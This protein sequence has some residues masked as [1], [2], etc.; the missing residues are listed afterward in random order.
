MANGNAPATKPAAPPETKPASPSETK[1]KAGDNGPPAPDFALAAQI[2]KEQIDGTA[3]RRA[4]MNGDL[5]AAWK[6]VE[7]EAHVNKKAAEDA[8]AIARMSDETQSD[9]LRSLFG[10]MAPL[11]IGVRRDL[12]DLAEGVPGLMIP[13]KDAPESE[14]EGGS[15]AE[16]AMRETAKSQ[17]Q[18]Q[19]AKQTPAEPYSGDDSDLAGS[20]PGEVARRAALAN[21]AIDN[22]TKQ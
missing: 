21:A 8:R 9:Y 7:D 11:G 22:L 16:K 10:L 18:A 3:E 14:L 12:V 19:K 1:R 5:S 17:A 2:I 6:R 20:T 15:V 4:K 13:L